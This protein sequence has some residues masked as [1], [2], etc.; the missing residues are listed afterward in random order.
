M[1]A[2]KMKAI[3]ATGYGSPSV[4]ELQNVNRPAVKPNEVLVKIHA[5][6]VTRADAMMRTG[7]PYIGRL[8]LGLFKP[9]NQIWG[10]SFSG[11]VEAVGSDVSNFQPGQRVFGE[12]IETFGAYAEYITVPADGTVMPLPENISFEDA[13]GIGDGPV[14][15]LNFLRNVSGGIKPGQKVLVNGASGALGTAAVQLAK[16]FGAEVTGVCSTR[17][18]GLVKSLGADYVI[19]YTKHDFTRNGQSY[20]VIYDTVGKRSFKDCKRVLAENGQYLSPVLNF[21]LLLQMMWTSAFSSKKAKFAATGM[22]KSPEIN[23]MLA[24]LIDIIRQGRLKTIIDRQYPLEKVSEAH[25]YVSAGHKKGNVV[26][27]IQ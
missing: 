5:T 9:K 15:S 26:I 19:D 27:A 17:N 11:I 21:K 24:E 14:T 12:N 20:D 23:E 10:T 16:Q 7:K 2:N 3:I 6:T 22:L 1:Q 13:A 4:F 25:S 8:M 18:I